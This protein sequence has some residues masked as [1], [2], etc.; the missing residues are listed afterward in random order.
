M[1][2]SQPTHTGS[3]ANFF[4]PGPLGTPSPMAGST[5][6]SS[7]GT[8]RNS[9]GNPN[10]SQPVVGGTKGLNPEPRGGLFGSNSGSGSGSLF[11]G[12]ATLFQEGAKSSPFGSSSAFGSTTAP[13]T[14]FGTYGAASN[15]SSNKPPSQPNPFLPLHSGNSQSK[16]DSTVPFDK[17]S[18]SS[19]R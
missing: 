14:G 1:S 5:T 18:N 4:A 11:Q 3:G 9:F 10:G 15:G 12:G 13:N 7:T 2:A 19:R 8:T 6:N 17:L 16:A